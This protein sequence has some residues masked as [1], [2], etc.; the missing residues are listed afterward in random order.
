MDEITLTSSAQLPYLHAVIEESLRIYPPVADTLPRVTP[1]E[2][3]A[4]AGQWVPGNTSVGFNQ[5][6]GYHDPANFADPEVFA[7]ERFLPDPPAKYMNDNKEALQPFS[8]GP[9]NCLGKNL[10][11]NEMRSLLARVIYAYDMELCPE[12]QNW[13][14]QKTWVIWE[15]PA[16][17]VQLRHRAEKA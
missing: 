6:S 1:P 16:L 5:W 17:M 4:I 14:N 12:S 11:Y 15:K 3:A 7:P 8:V 9:R 2:G 13:L 10:A